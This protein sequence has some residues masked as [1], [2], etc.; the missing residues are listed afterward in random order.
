MFKIFFIEK[1]ID[2]FCR[3]ILFSGFPEE[4][5]DEIF[6]WCTRIELGERISLANAQFHRIA[7]RYMHVKRIHCLPNLHFCPNYIFGGGQL[8]RETLRRE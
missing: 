8:Y 3:I 7:F 5:L 4:V 1:M 2:I 6:N